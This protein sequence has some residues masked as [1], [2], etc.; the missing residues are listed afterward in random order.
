MWSTSLLGEL[1]PT[2]QQTGCL[3]KYCLEYARHLWSYPWAFV[4][5]LGAGEIKVCGSQ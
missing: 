1:H 5:R 3:A 4:F 2:T